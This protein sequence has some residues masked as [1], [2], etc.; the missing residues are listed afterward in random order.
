MGGECGRSTR[1]LQRDG[2]QV[3]SKTKGG[4]FFDFSFLCASGHETGR[5]WPD[6]D[7]E[8]RFEN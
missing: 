2:R 4:K 7:R 8:I 6:G 5:L 1:K 3:D